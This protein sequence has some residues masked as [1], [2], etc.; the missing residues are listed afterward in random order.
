MTT[1]RINQVATVLRTAGAP[2][3]A[4]WIA[5]RARNALVPPPDAAVPRAQAAREPFDTLAARMRSA[6]ATTGAFYLEM[7]SFRIASWHRTLR[8]RCCRHHH[9]RRCC[10]MAAAATTTTTRQTGNAVV[11]VSTRS[12]LWPLCG[13]LFLARTNLTQ[14]RTTAA[15]AKCCCC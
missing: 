15:N 11:R 14:V 6:D 8:A 12:F 3:A 7:I 5:T 13:L 1:G 9:R 10:R 4:G 2:C